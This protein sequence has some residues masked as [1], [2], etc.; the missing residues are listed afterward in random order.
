MRPLH[1]VNYNWHTDVLLSMKNILLMLSLVLCVVVS[2]SMNVNAND[3]K[4]RIE[5]DQVNMR[6]Y[7]QFIAQIEHDLPVGTSFKDVEKYLSDYEIE[8]SHAPS[9]GCF[10]FMVKK[11]YSAFF[12]FITDLQI[13]IYVSEEAGVTDIKSRLIETAF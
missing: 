11:I 12:V 8:F 5:P 7:E 6:N 4:E 9:E 3:R 10:K 13:K 1:K 2:I